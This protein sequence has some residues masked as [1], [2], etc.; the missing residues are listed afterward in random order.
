MAAAANHT[1]G[2]RALVKA[3]YLVRVRLAKLVDEATAQRR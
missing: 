3:G 1:V 2:E